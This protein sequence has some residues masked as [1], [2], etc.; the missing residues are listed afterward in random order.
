MALHR[1]HHHQ[2]RD[3]FW[4]EL[5]QDAE[6]ALDLPGVF[7]EKGGS[8][9]NDNSNQQ[10]TVVSVV[11][12]T[13]SATGDGQVIGWR[14]VTTHQAS[15]TPTPEPTKSSKSDALVADT[16]SQRKTQ[17]QP[18]ETSTGLP[19][20]IAP[21]SSTGVDNNNLAVATNSLNVPSSTISPTSSPTSS[22]VAKSGGMSVGGEVG[23]AIGV[24]GIVGALAALIFFFIKKRR[25]AREKA[26]DEKA[27]VW[28]GAERTASTRT[29]ANAPRL[30]LRPVT[31]FLPNLGGDRRQSRGNAL[32]MKAAAPAPGNNG[33]RPNSWE[34][35]MSQQEGN[36]HNPF[37]AHAE[38]IDAANARGAPV[39]EAVGPAGEIVAAGA[40]AGA[41]AGLTRGA[42]KRENNQQK[43]FT[44]RNPTLPP[45]SPVPTEFSMS[46]EPNGPSAS[47]PGAAAIAAAGGPPNTA[48][49]RVQLDFKPSMDD[50]LE[51]RAGQ[52]IRLLHE[53]DDGWVSFHEVCDMYQANIHRPSA[54]VSTARLRVSSHVPACLSAQSSPAPSRTAPAPAARH[55]HTCAVLLASL[56]RCRQA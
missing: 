24:I 37:G 27:D 47:T 8:S 7:A 55:H 19:K 56:A 2:K 22:A 46:S 6:N 49:H 39:V 9:N 52:L 35:P 28:G 51:L 33:R 40:A 30:S 44:T 42:S 45:L 32:A 48:V 17:Q 12:V 53:Y 26:D 1:H 38:T 3:N 50:E 15:P 21:P 29:A 20:S 11:Y 16:S 23:V 43:D 18:K 41:A 13:K 5:A 14:T 31:Q 4:T 34:M 10:S 36:R 25:D 54:S